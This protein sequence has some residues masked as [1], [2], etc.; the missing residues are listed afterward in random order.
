MLVGREAEQRALDAL[1]Q[2]ARDERSAALVLRGEPGI[3]KT[4]L[5][6]Y[7]AEHA[8]D[9]RVLRCVGIE[10]E[11]ELPF[12]GMHQ[13]VR[14][15]LDLVD[16]L[17]APQAAA[18]RSALG[19]SFDGVHDRF[20]VSVGLLSLLAEACD[21]GPVLCCVD[22]AQWLD[23][24]SAE[25][26]VFAARRFEAE[27][28][29]LLMAVREGEARRFDA[30]GVPE[31]ELE[32]LSE[33]DARALLTAQLDRAPAPDVVA[34]LLG[35][36]HGNPL[37]LMELPTALTEAQL[38]GAEPILGPP[39]VRGAV[40][41]A[42]GARIA[43][44]P[45]ATRRVML[46]A[47]ADEAG[48]V[49]SLERAARHQG[50]AMADLDAAE[51][52]GLLRVDGAVAFRHPLVRSV[53]YRS[54]THSERRAA[55]EALAAVVDDPMRGAW[56]RALVADGAD[57]AIAA[58]LE[59][60]ARQAAGRAA[61]ATASAAFERA[62]ELSEDRER[63]GH[64]LTWASQAAL[65]A[66]RLDAA[67]ALA[68]RAAPLVVAPLDAAQL[69]LIRGANAARRGSPMD[70]HTLLREG[71]IGLVD[72]APAI[73]ME[74]V[75]WSIFVGLQGG[76]PERALTDAD[77][78][79]A[80]IET[81]SAMGRFGR[82]VVDGAFALLARDST[83]AHERLSDAI[84]V[85]DITDQG[86]SK[87]MPA[88]VHLFMGDFTRA[89]TVARRAIAGLRELGTIGPL[90]GSLPLL[91]S[92]EMASRQ[93]REAAA[94]TAEGLE[95]AEPLGY[96]NDTTGLLGVKARVAAFQGHEEE[97]RESAEAAMRRAVANGVGWAMVNARLA[98]A[99]LELGLGNAREAIEQL[100]QLDPTPFPPIAAMAT[101]D[102]VDAA[103]RLGEHDRA[104]QWL[105]RFAQWAPVNGGPLVNG[106]L[107]RCRAMLSNDAGDAEALFDEAL[108]HHAADV[109]AFERARTQLSF[110]ERL[111]RERR[112]IEARTQL[113]A[114][115]DVFEGL[116]A[117][118]WA[119]R[120]RAEL[121]AT[122]E[123]ARKRDA[124]TIDELTP[125][126][127]RIASLVAGGASN[128][129]VAAQIFVSPKTVEYHLRKVF[130]K[131]GVAS[132]VELARI[133][134]A[135]QAQGSD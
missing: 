8:H 96:E 43:R 42:F 72:V 34:T 123:T 53:V 39:P 118:L 52:D 36:A 112:K 12:A 32:G 88:F 19:L 46:L 124:S 73:A 109:P 23:Q 7:A 17:P 128:R 115:L 60:A 31:L 33:A 92:A 76:W 67:V 80:T 113:R 57:E 70:T 85:G 74:M 101:P 1:L 91:A 47:A 102:Y 2:S 21:G 122:G 99:E 22:D 107:A 125:Q 41:A 129:D 108:A 119:E 49:A 40:E 20:L 106:L 82:A 37:A 56:H 98:L 38:D 131:L 116:G 103:L 134:L 126:E 18:L 45:D 58:Q 10:A 97:C 133:P 44:L 9:M 4:A 14:P 54:A 132:R 6:A 135:M 75:L 90:A 50:L 111:R 63:A 25:A 71:G 26:L 127:L 93:V 94:T 95:L 27:P 84:A 16:R 30:P 114:A 69:K 78:V 66:G 87:I 130:L 62:A 13:L 24:P 121:R 29:A 117:T 65:D 51:H 120:T 104:A 11:H 64:R 110:G 61:H 81:D 55:H 48:D 100:E 59:E 28:I 89:T 15:C 77:R 68:D 5:L 86:R 3:G 105:E 83:R 35:T 79:L